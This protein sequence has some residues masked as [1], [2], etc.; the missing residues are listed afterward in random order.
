MSAENLPGL[1][2]GREFPGGFG[3]WRAYDRGDYL[4]FG[5]LLLVAATFS[6]Y[7][8][9]NGHEVLAILVSIFPILGWLSS[10]PTIP[11]VLLGVS[12]PAFTSLTGNGLGS[13]GGSGYNASLSDFVLLLIGAGI[14]LNWLTGKSEP[15]LR[16][17]RPVALPVLAYSGVMVIVL[18]VHFGLRASF[19]TGQRFELFLLPLI[20][21]AFAA[22]SGRHM[23]VLQGYVVAT[24]LLAVVWPIDHLGLQKNPVGQLI[25]NAILLLV[26][27]RG[28]R[29]FFPC[30]ALLVPGLVLT[31][32]RG[33]I[34][35][36][37]IGIMV[38]VALQRTRARPVVTRVLPLALLALAAF[39]FAPAAVQG[40]VTTLHAGTS[41]PGQYAIYLRQGFAKD[42]HHIIDE[43]PW[44]GVGI[45]NFYAADSVFSTTPVLDPHQVILLQE[46]EGGYPLGAAFLLLIGGTMLILRRMRQVDVGPAAAGVLIA[47]AAH[48]LFDIY[49]V[50][51]TPLLSW[52]LVGMACGGLVNLREAKPAT[53]RL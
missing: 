48:G 29:R 41:T 26:G 44:T 42:A 13:T 21:G 38:I 35:G 49:W 28:L 27:V 7:A 20:V 18:S 3:F 22:L 12:I 23:R 2:R 8:L 36:A 33:A 10:R 37:A 11:L 52:L 4:A 30:L 40:R 51:G 19:K 39:A 5:L 47:T 43:H 14:L 31:V 15:V 17:L 34:G 9:V 45:G 50:R 24:T 53:Q 32:S 25:A 46:A 6:A 1:S 16:A